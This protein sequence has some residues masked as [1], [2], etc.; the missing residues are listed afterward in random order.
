MASAARQLSGEATARAI[1]VAM[2]RVN[3][4][5]GTTAPEGWYN[6]DNSPT[7]WWSR[8]PVA[9][10]VFKTTPWPRSVHRHDVLKGLPFA[11]HSVDFIYSSHTF[12]HF[13][14]PQSL[15]L[16]KEC[17]RVLKPE[18]ILRLVVPDLEQIARDYLADPAPMASH[19]FIERLLL[20]HSWRDL[21]HPGAHHSQMFDARSLTAM[22]HEAGFNAP[23]ISSFGASE[24]PGVMDV[25]LEER[26]DESLYIEAQK[27]TRSNL[28]IYH[29]AQTH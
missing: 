17:L 13:T 25:E 4:G 19:R 23:Q 27:T 22:L 15:A 6:I 20:S 3:I 24:I 9:S 11:D 18:G 14:Y 10:K 16:T 26:R 1:A 21:L 28:K 8:I 2:L 29:H 7:I 12:E 5:C